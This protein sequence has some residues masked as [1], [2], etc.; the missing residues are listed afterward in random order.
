MIDEWWIVTDLKGNGLGL[1]EVLSWSLPGSTEKDREEP[2]SVTLVLR[3]WFKPITPRILVRT[4]TATLTCSVLY[5]FVSNDLINRWWFMDSWIL[6]FLTCDCRITHCHTSAS[7]LPDLLPSC[8]NRCGLGVSER[9]SLFITSN[10]YCFHQ[11]LI[12]FLDFMKC[13]YLFFSAVLSEM[14]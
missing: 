12:N 1:T 14:F 13:S 9:G 4:I 5:I 6:S 2:Q 7:G 10:P 3:S 8:P 11:H